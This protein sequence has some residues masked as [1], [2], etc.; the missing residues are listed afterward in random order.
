LYNH[1][2][3]SHGFPDK[4]FRVQ[5]KVKDLINEKGIRKLSLRFKE[6]KKQKIFEM[7]GESNPNFSQGILA[8][9]QTLYAGP[10]GRSYSDSHG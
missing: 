7:I 9:R 8:D 4:H 10:G 6:I 2:Y 3:S 1:V 5:N